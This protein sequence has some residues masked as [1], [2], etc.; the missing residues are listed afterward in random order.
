MISLVLIVL[1]SRIAEW[2]PTTSRASSAT[3]VL[4][5][6]LRW[7]S[8]TTITKLIHRVHLHALEQSEGKVIVGTQI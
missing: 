7:P 1:K 2:R 8:V 5:L 3:T 4:S 6:G